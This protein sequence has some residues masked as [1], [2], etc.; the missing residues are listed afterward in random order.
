MPLSTLFLNRAVQVGATTTLQAFRMKTDV[1]NG[2]GIMS[3]GYAL[4]LKKYPVET[5]ARQERLTVTLTLSGLD[6]QLSILI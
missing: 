2:F 3:P 5:Q 6:F 1:H 4:R